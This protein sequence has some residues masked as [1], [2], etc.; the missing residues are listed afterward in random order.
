M[1]FVQRYVPAIA[2]CVA[3]PAL[4][5]VTLLFF[6]PSLAQ[7][8]VAAVDVQP[9]ATAIK[10]LAVVSLA[11]GM[12]RLVMQSSL[13]RRPQ[14]IWTA[15]GC[16]AVSALC[17]VFTLPH[18]PLPALLVAAAAHLFFGWRTAQRG[19]AHPVSLPQGLLRFLAYFVMGYAITFLLWALHAAH[20]DDM[21]NYLYMG[22][23]ERAAMD[24][25]L[26]AYAQNPL[27]DMPNGVASYLDASMD[28]AYLSHM[29]EGVSTLTFTVPFTIPNDKGATHHGVCGFSDGTLSI[30]KGR[31]DL[32]S[33]GILSAEQI[34]LYFLEP[35]VLRA[36]AT[37]FMLANR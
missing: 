25:R 24:A 5:A 10:I 33:D 34:R 21:K 4:C 13:H 29:A 18:L 35:I 12:G 2:S 32:S 27:F 7:T 36:C 17:L 19:Q 26:I 11:L 6:Y 14:Q 9:V 16:A 8:L 23:A 1:A 28:A 22:T 37:A 15:R 20:M 30:E 3:I 31:S